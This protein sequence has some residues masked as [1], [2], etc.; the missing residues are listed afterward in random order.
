MIMDVT[1]TKKDGKAVALLVGRLDGLSS[2][3]AAEKILSVLD[4]GIELTI[5]MEQCPYVSS[6]GLRV[7]LSAGKWAKLHNG[8]MKIVN[9]VEEVKE[10][11]EI[12]GF[13][14]IFNGF[15]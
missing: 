11:M 15:A 10:V 7:L 14:S 9:L 4:D 2:D 5:D 12:T 6:A 3:M 8:K 13:A 1:I